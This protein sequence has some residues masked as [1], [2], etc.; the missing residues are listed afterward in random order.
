MPRDSPRRELLAAAATDYALG[1]GLVGLSLRP[2][3]AALGTSDRMLLYHFAGKDDLIATMLRVANDRSVAAIRALPPSADVH[4]AV[5]RLWETVTS[6]ALDRC[7]RMY[8]EAA[9]LGLFG[10]EPYAS[11]VRE[12]NAAW[13]AAVG[14]HLVA[15]GMPPARSARA[16]RLLDAAFMGF[17]LDLPLG[18]DPATLARSVE[19]LADAVVAIAS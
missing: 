9:A 8:V 15:S 13:V 14:E 5:R 11:V 10:R 2:L 18:A 1:H 12:A 19:D 7:Q 3:A 4:G 16:V 6:P 17:Q